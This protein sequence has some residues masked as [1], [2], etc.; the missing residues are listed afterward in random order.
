MYH[1]MGPGNPKR[2]REVNEITEWVV[3]YWTPERH[4]KRFLERP[5][6]LKFMLHLPARAKVFLDEVF[7]G[8]A[9]RVR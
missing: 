4:E 7:V 5:Q 2:G 6:A 3:V 1:P 9:V 8:E